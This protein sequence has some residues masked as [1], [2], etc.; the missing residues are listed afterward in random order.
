M[1][2]RYIYTCLSLYRL[3][4]PP[5]TAPGSAGQGDEH[6]DI[7]GKVCIVYVCVYDV[8]MMYKI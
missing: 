4:H 1:Y 7:Q 8:Y 5:A 6:E 2:T 3:P